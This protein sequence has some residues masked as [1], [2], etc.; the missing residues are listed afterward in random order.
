MQNE[1]NKSA[2]TTIRKDGWS[3]NGEE[4]NGDGG[5]QT[6]R[7]VGHNDSNEEDDSVEPFVSKDEGD[8]EE[9]HSEED[10]HTGDD[11]DE[12]GNLTSDR[13]LTDLKPRSKVG[14][15]THHST[16]TRKDHNTSGSA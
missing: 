3:S 6:L 7:Y 5:Q 1:V 15:S 16:I 8:D 11:L 10:C 2:I 12:V 9:R 4:T 13:G 14:N